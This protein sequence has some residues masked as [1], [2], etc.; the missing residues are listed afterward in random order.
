MDHSAVIVSQVGHLTV[1]MWE[2]FEC[3]LIFGNI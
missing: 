3:D 2:K 1:E